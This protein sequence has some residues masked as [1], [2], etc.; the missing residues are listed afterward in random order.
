MT[1]SVWDDASYRCIRGGS[2]ANGVNYCDVTNRSYAGFPNIMF[3]NGGFR[4]CRDT[5]CVA[6]P[7]GT[8]QMGR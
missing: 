2:W 6:I 3:D 1:S 4:V 7:A 5:P 8:F